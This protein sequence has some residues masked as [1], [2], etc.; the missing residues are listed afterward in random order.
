ME[1]LLTTKE[2]A[3][4]LGISETTLI[5]HRLKG[6]GPRYVKI[7]HLVRYRQVDADHWV[8]KHLVILP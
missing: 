7:G 3:Q 8:V 4:Y 2:L 6:T 5:Q 1:K